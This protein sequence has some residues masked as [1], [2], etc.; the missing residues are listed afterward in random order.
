LADRLARALHRPCAGAGL[1][2]KSTAE[3][4]ALVRLCGEHG[5]PIVPQGGNSGMAGGATPDASGTAM[6][7]SLRG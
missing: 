2:G 5:V 4:S 3:V 7:L 1:A 6:I